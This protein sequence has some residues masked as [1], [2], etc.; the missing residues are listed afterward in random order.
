MHPN[1][2]YLFFTSGHTSPNDLWAFAPLEVHPPAVSEQTVSQVT[3][4]AATLR[5]KVDPGAAASSYRFQYTSEAD[6]L[7]NGWANAIRLPLP[8]GE[9]GAQAPA[10]AVSA[11]IAGLAPGTEYRFRI[12][13]TN[14]CKPL[15]PTVQC[16]TQGEGKQGE[17]GSDASFSTYPEPFLAGPC[18]NEALRSGPSALLPDCRAYELVAGRIGR[19]GSGLGTRRKLCRRARQLARHGERGKRAV[20]FDQRRPAGVGRQRRLRPL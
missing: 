17:E 8:E 2:G 20:R 1:R 14:H 15:E 11:P 16:V 6:F 13:A 7:E 10:T 4:A 9:I 19:P 12:V 5:G 18:P 3:T